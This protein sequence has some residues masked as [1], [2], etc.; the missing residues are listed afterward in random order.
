MG[1]RDEQDDD[2]TEDLLDNEKMAALLYRA[3]RDCRELMASWQ[4]GADVNLEEQ[5]ALF[6]IVSRLYHDLG[7]L[8]PAALKETRAE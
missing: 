4:R 2:I 8:L 1:S 3:N 6:V 5:H 7:L